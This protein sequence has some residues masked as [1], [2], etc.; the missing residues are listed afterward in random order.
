VFAN[1]CGV[2]GEARRTRT[3]VGSISCGV[4]MDGWRSGRYATVAETTRPARPHVFLGTLAGGAAVSL[5][6]IASIV[7]TALILPVLSATAI[8]VAL[9][10]ALLAWSTGSDRNSRRVTPWDVAGGLVLVGFVAGMMSDPVNVLQLFDP[11]AM[12]R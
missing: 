12:P 4:P 11:G 2:R 9:A 10:V 5:A 6:L 3:G 1:G 7:P 8:A